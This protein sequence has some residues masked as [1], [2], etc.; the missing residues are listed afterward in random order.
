MKDSCICA[1]KRFVNLIRVLAHVGVIQLALMALLLVFSLSWLPHIIS[2]DM[3]IWLDRLELVET[4]E[5][6]QVELA[7]HGGN[8][9]R[10]NTLLL[11]G[12]R[13]D[14]LKVYWISYEE[15]R[16][17]LDE[18]EFAREQWTTAQVEKRYNLLTRLVSNE[19][20]VSFAQ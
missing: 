17:V 12:K 5:P 3:T 11:N 15:C 1:G 13:A 7:A 2:P 14:L 18:E 20:G 16:F 6:G 4:N 10:V 9:F 8:M 19:I